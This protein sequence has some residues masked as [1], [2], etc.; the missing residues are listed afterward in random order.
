[1]DASEEH[2]KAKKN[3]GPKAPMVCGRVIYSCW[4]SLAVYYLPHLLSL[5]VVHDSDIFHKHL[6]LFVDLSLMHDVRGQS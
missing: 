3:L 5:L 1:M 2:M 4:I 6:F